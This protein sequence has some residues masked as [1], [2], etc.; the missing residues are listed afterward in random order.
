MTSPYAHLVPRAPAANVI[1]RRRMLKLAANNPAM[2]RALIEMCRRDVLFFI[3]A[4]CWV[5]EPRDAAP[6]ELPFCAWPHQVPALQTLENSL[7]RYDVGFEKSRGEGATW[8]YCAVLTKHW[9]FTSRFSAGIISKT[10]EDVDTKD[11]VGTVMPKIDFLISKLP[12]WMLPAGFDPK[13]HR[14]HT[15]RKLVNPANNAMIVGFAATNDVATGGRMTVLVWDEFAKFPKE[16]ARDAVKSTQPVTNCRWFISTP[17]GTNNEYYRIMHA[18]TRIVKIRLHWSQNPSRNRG[19]YRLV[20]GRCVAVDPVNNPVP[21]GYAERVKAIHADIAASGFKLDD[22]LRSPWYDNECWGGMTPQGVAQ[23]YDI[24]YVGS[25]DPYF[26]PELK[27][28]LLRQTVRDP[29]LRGRLGFFSHDRV[30][31]WFEAAG[32]G[33][34]SLWVP[35]DVQGWPA[36][37]SFTIG[38]DVAAGTG[39]EY[40]SNSVAQ[41]LNKQTG[42]QV[43]E[44]VSNTTDPATFA[45]VLVALA[46]FFRGPNGRGAFLNWETNGTAGQI[47]TNRIIEIGYSNVGHW[48]GEGKFTARTSKNVGFHSGE[49]S[50]AKLLGG[51]KGGGLRQALVDGRVLARS[52]FVI[53]ELTQFEYEGGKVVHKGSTKKDSQAEVGEEHGDRVIA[54]AI[55]ALDIAQRERTGPTAEIPLAPSECPEGTIGYRLH[56]AQLLEEASKYDEHVW[57]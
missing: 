48:E 18:K 29:V 11:N 2:Q 21:K 46:W 24:D 9:L 26:A 49:K 45:E 33:E 23:E 34:L 50:K 10:A 43:A 31:P 55:A 20:G 35:L 42:E 39:G 41:V 1:W 5:V 17:K 3:L 28:R 36:P 38:G 53:E 30:K 4:F 22:R 40:S 57:S 54:L 47:C 37:G 7:G 32:S 15:D 12:S 56:K 19:L 44:W 16:S 14:T 27:E 13:K 52:R 8:M 51:H 6:M 25:G